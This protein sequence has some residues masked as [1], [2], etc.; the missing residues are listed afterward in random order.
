VAETD[1]LGIFIFIL[2]TW[3][4]RRHRPLCRGLI[5]H[6]AGPWSAQSWQWHPSTRLTSIRTARLSLLNVNRHSNGFHRV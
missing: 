5:K 3:A 1:T 6:N 4:D 2:K